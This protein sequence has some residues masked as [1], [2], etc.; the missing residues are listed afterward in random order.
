MPRNRKITVP[1]LCKN[2]NEFY[3]F[4][5]RIACGP[6]CDASLEDQAANV[7]ALK[8]LLHEYLAL[9]LSGKIS[10]YQMDPLS[11]DVSEAFN[12][13]LGQ[14][15]S[16]WTELGVVMKEGEDGSLAVDVEATKEKING[17]REA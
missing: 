15:N 2:E 4:M 5:F 7:F 17:N 9:Y 1:H 10:A 12:D 16:M 8:V 11:D 3:K 14:I 6:G 13:M